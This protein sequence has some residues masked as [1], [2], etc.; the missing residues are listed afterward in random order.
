LVVLFR[1]IRSWFSSPVHFVR[2]GSR[3]HVYSILDRAH[4]MTDGATSAILFDDLW[5]L[6]ESFKLNGLISRIRAGEIAS[7][8]LEARSFINQRDH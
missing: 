1:V 6:I 7:S 4:C 5:E 2:K 8:T 3:Y